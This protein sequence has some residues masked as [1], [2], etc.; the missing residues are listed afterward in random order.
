MIRTLVRRIERRRA[1]QKIRS[2][3]PIVQTR[4]F[5]CDLLVRAHEDVGRNI[6]FDDF[7]KDDLQHFLGYLRAGDVVFDVGANVGAYCVTAGRSQP[8]ARVFA[9]EPIP[10]NVA[11]IGTS[12]LANRIENVEVAKAC[13]SDMPGE[14]EFTVSEDSAY[15]S[16]IDTH[17][18]P[19][20]ARV[21]CQAITL[22]D[23]C[24]QRGLKS[25]D[26]MKID[27]EGAE[28][29]VLQGARLM[30]SDRQS[31]PRLILIELYDQN[32]EAFGTSIAEI[33]GL[34]ESSHYRPYVL[35]EGK[36]VPFSPAHHNVH[37]NVFFEH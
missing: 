20:A 34:M 35:I 25:P 6:I 27:V 2:G 4:F 10:L 29:R 11:L 17:R 12:L 33:V 31:S 7:E 15:S 8:S 21:R 14:V 18:K 26:V 30:L 22:D 28:L 5:G 19:E 3:P 9:F 36:K 1:S 37:Y 32:L 16:M 23:F 24:K 13:V